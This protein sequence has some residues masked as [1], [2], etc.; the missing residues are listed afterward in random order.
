MRIQSIGMRLTYLTLLAAPWAAGQTVTVAP[1]N[2][3]AATKT[4]TFTFQAKTTILSFTCSPLTLE[5]SG[6]STCSVTLNQNAVAPG[7]KVNI[8]PSVGLSAPASITIATGVATGTFVVTRAASA[9][10]SGLPFKL[11]E[12][13][14]VNPKN[15]VCLGLVPK[16]QIVPMPNEIRIND[17]VRK[18]YTVISSIDGCLRLNFKNGFHKDEILRIY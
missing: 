14:S 18:D 10:F 9:S 3:P 17:V 11:S 13:I 6:T 2:D 4:V 16:D 8:T 1:Q 12:G 7:F 5:P 15:E